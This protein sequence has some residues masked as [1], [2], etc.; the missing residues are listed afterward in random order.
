LQQI[1]IVVNQGQL[2]DRPINV[3]PLFYLL[4]GKVQILIAIL[5]NSCPLALQIMQGLINIGK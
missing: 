5:L 1:P 4:D 3:A 2:D